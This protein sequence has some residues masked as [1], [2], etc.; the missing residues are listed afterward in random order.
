MCD[1]CWSPARPG[2]TDPPEVNILSVNSSF[3]RSGCA[4]FDRRHLRWPD[5]RAGHT[6]ETAYLYTVIGPG[7]RRRR[8]GACSHP[9]ESSLIICY[10]RPTSRASITVSS[11][12]CSAARRR[13]CA[14]TIFA[15]EGSSTVTTGS[16]PSPLLAFSISSSISSTV[17]T[18]HFLLKNFSRADVA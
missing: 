3:D 7:L 9:D 12:A 14:T 15:R 5:V 4:G 1:D 11:S 16:G 8:E 13:I 10:D 2:G 17:F 6:A 18:L